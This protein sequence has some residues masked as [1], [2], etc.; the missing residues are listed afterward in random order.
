MDDSYPAA[1]NLESRIVAGW[2]ALELGDLEA[3]RAV[4]RDVYDVNPTHPALPLLAAGIRRVRPRQRPWRGVILLLLLAVA[5]VA[6]VAV[7]TRTS[8]DESRPLPPSEVAQASVTPEPVTPPVTT[9]TTGEAE[10]SE[11]AAP[12]RRPV[13]APVDEDVLV[14]QAIA[15]FETSYKSRWGALAFRHCDIARDG[16]SATATCRAGRDAGATD[17]EA[18]HLWTFSLRQADGAWRIVSV[19][20]SAM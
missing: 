8:R 5:A 13:P 17:I 6:L 2:S 20:P 4:L 16:E 15:R 3:A 14:R 19:E 12:A 10:V 18:D 9:G 7:R 1:E 11:P